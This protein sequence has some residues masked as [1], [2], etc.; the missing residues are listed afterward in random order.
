M[1]YT[2]VANFSMIDLP[3]PSASVGIIFGT[4]SDSCPGMRRDV[5]VSFLTWPP[6]PP[7]HVVLG[8][9]IVQL[10]HS[11]HVVVRATQRY[12][13]PPSLPGSGT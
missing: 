12:W 9:D 7:L 8:H 3:Q 13:P 10:M 11:L 5:A 6:L 1:P 2:E 4:R